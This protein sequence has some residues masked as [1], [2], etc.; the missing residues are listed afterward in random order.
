MGKYDLA[1]EWKNAAIQVD[2]NMDFVR[3]DK[4]LILLEQKICKEAIEALDRATQLN[5]ND[6]Q[7][8]ELM[9]IAIQCAQET[10]S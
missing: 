6:E 9:E 7:S 8:K 4:G 1:I 10:N 3:F 2:P 5:P